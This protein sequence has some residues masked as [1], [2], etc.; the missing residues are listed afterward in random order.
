MTMNPKNPEVAQALEDVAAGTLEARRLLIA[1][2]QV[3]HDIRTEVFQER[4]ISIPEWRSTAVEYA[5]RYHERIYRAD[6]LTIAEVLRDADHITN[7]ILGATIP[8]VNAEAP[9]SLDAGTGE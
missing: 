9:K 6:S 4:N 8:E 2:T 1:E 3:V 7:Y 5:I